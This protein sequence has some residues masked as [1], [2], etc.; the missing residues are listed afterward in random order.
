MIVFLLGFQFQIK[1]EIKISMKF[2]AGSYIT[3]N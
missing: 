3:L 2:I 1:V